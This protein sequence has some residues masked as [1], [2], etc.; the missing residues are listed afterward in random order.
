MLKDLAR[1][2]LSAKD[3]QIMQLEVRARGE[4]P[5]LFPEGA[6]YIIPYFTP[7]GEPR[8]DVYRYRFLEDTR[9][10][11][12]KHITK[13]RRYTQPPH[14]PPA[15]YFPPFTEWPQMLVNNTLPLIITEGE[16]K[17]AAA[18]KLG[19]PTLGLG[20]VWS[21]RSKAQSVRLLPELRDAVNWENRRV[22]IAYDSDAA[23][24]P[25]V[26]MAELALA[27]ELLQL[28]AMPHIV[29]LQH[30]RDGTKQGIDDFL[31]DNT[32]AK[33]LEL[34]ES[35]PQFRAAE[36]LHELNTEVVY[37]KDPGAVFVRA[38]GQIVRPV[39]FT[40][41]R[42][43][44]RTY[45]KVKNMADGG[46]KMEE[47]ST[48][49]DWLKWPHRAAAERFVFDPSEGPI[50]AKNE[51]NLWKGW[52]YEPVKGNV[53]PWTTL[54][55]FIFDGA[56]DIRKYV[57][58]W[59]A[60][61][62]QHPGVKLRNGVA[63]WGSRKGTGKSLIGYTLGDLYGEAFMEINDEHVNGRV[64]F[65]HWARHRH[66]ILG[67]E[68]TGDDARQVANRI[69]AMIT[70]ERIEIN[71]KNVPQYT[72][73]DCINY[74]F[75]SNAPDCFYLEEDDRRLLIH[76]VR[77]PPLE[78][79]FYQQIYDT[80]RRSDEG[81]RALMYHLMYN[82][83][84][85]DFKPMGRPPETRDKREMFAL[86]RTD[87]EDWLI[88]MRAEPSIVCSK[89]NNSDLVTSHELMALYDPLQTKRVSQ[90]LMS[91]KMKEAGYSVI[92]P[93]DRPDNPQVRIGDKLL[94]LYALRNEKKWFK[95][96]SDMLRLEYERTRGLRAKKF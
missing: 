43:S 51:V 72:I 17:S 79:R 58:Q 85:S 63:V 44:D 95:A 15:V 26:C 86:T 89:L 94:R 49:A 70:R 37:I 52:P 96:T 83:D 4:M 12:T 50:T 33:L 29:R 11:F 21:F 64:S 27:R 41:H 19:L 78:D 42:F 39:D 59:A 71:I 20:G 35:S 32:A 36:A 56:P 24:N 75:T 87:L 84:T 69:K 9:T 2:G 25:D 55:D 14:S 23:T 91:R 16:K 45:L 8:K 5:D 65:N 92:Y 34:C 1:S 10:G 7:N 31:V 67:D 47:R 88:N 38:N 60:Y 76:E 53:M 66:F 81:R 82:V 40:G 68:I 80:W 74:Y 93:T 6:G 13:A 73:T 18:T 22:Y 61:P 28:G 77:L 90:T 3:A 46:T 57:E 62:I 48:A 30:K 54:L